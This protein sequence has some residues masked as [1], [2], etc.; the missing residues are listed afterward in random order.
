MNVILWNIFYAY[1]C[2]RQ[3]NYDSMKCVEEVNMKI[4]I[5]LQLQII[6]AELLVQLDILFSLYST[7]SP[8]L[9]K[10]QLLVLQSLHKEHTGTGTLLA[11][12]AAGP[13]DAKSRD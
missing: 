3:D 13:F 10:C 11:D 4:N 8:R 5:N 7:P 6:C 9:P 12:S 2:D 1:I